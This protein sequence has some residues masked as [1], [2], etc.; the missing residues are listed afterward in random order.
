MVWGLCH[1]DLRRRFCGDG[2]NDRRLKGE[3]ALRFLVLGDGEVIFGEVGDDGIAV[4][5]VNVDIEEDK[6]R[7][8]AESRCWNGLLRVVLGEEQGASKE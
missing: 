6:R 8:H 2:V 1:L 3:D 7:G 4:L 5:V